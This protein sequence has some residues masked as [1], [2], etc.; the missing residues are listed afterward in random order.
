MWTSR[1]QMSGR[2]S[3]NSLT[4]SRPFRASATISSSGHTIASWRRSASRS[5][6]SSSAI[7]AV[8]VGVHVCA[9]MSISTMAPRGVLGVRRRCAASPKISCSRSRR[10]VSPV[11]RPFAD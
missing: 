11:P 4:A 5:S 10:V 9:G 8:G 6:G 7:N 1:K 2:R 3:S